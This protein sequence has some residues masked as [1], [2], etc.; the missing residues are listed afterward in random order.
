M[1]EGL[2]PKIMFMKD[3]LQRCWNEVVF[4]CQQSMDQGSKMEELERKVIEATR[5]GTRDDFDHFIAH[6]RLPFQSMVFTWMEHPHCASSQVSFP[7]P[8]C[9]GPMFWHGGL[10]NLSESWKSTSIPSLKS[11]TP[12]SFPPNVEDSYT[13]LTVVFSLGSTLLAFVGGDSATVEEVV[14]GGNEG[15][16]GGEGE[17]GEH[18]GL[19]E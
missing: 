6:H 12:P 15:D 16:G 4:R 9:S 18:S 1:L 13:S 3:S 7:P 10:T 11:I 2:T 17:S 19:G 8:S 14:A 5:C